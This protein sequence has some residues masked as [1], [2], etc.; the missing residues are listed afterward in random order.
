[1][2]GRIE[3]DGAYANLVVP[4]ILNRSGLDPRDRGFVTDL[5]YGTTRMRRAC[6]YLV[7][8]FLISE[9]EPAVL[10]ALHVGAYQI[11]FA[12]V[13]AHAAVDATVG[14]VPKRVRGL[15]NAVLRRVNDNPVG[16]DDWPDDATRLSYP[17]WVVD[18]LVADL[19][20]DSA[21][22]ALE[23]MNQPASVVTRADGYR[24]DPSSQAVAAL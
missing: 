15:V 7:E 3:S 8:R 22:A 20:R 11:A 17:D 19:G 24:Q 21:L 23:T 1:A 9:V 18:R 2:L 4:Q 10:D 5:V 6:D 14:A 16:P 12:G 13:P